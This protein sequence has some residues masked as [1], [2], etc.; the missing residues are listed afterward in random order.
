MNS[1]FIPVLAVFSTLRTSN[2]FQDGRCRRNRNRRPWR[3]DRATIVVVAVCCSCWAG[4][5]GCRSSKKEFQRS[6]PG[7][8]RSKAYA[9][10][11]LESI[12]YCRPWTP[13][14]FGQEKGN[15][16]TTTY[17]NSHETTRIDRINCML[18]VLDFPHVLHSYKC[19]ILGNN[20]A[21]KTVAIV[22]SPSI[23]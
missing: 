10:T 14:P 21:D 16:R 9:R 7:G 3:R 22:D 13:I 8:H 19:S 2:Q 1:G 17:T 23:L 4:S 12:T 20:V 11:I 5:C 18:I 6:R 15:P